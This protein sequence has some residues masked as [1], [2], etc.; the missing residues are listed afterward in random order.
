M[1]SKLI[2]SRV[3]YPMSDF[4]NLINNSNRNT[5]NLLILGIAWDKSSSYRSGSV[6]GPNYIR[7][8]TSS[9]VYNSFTETGTDL[10]HRWKVIDLGNV[11]TGG[12]DFDEIIEYISDQ[13]KQ[14]RKEE[15][16]LF[17]GG[18]H[19]VTYLCLHA[20]NPSNTGIIYFD[21]HPDLYNDYD[22]DTY[23]HACVLRRILDNTE[24]RPQNVI[25]IGIRASTKEQNDFSSENGVLVFSRKEVEQFGY[26][27]IGDRIKEKIGHLEQI[28]ISIDLDVLDPAYAPGVGNPEPA[29]LS[30]PTIV[31]L[32]HELSGLPIKFFDIVEINPPHD[33]SNITGFAAAKIIK[34]MF[35]IIP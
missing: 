6:Q 5:K 15:P 19:L 12:K 20:I 30:M 14:Y 4:F 23:S 31:D 2:Y 11:D 35:G 29:G 7:N 25:Q 34:E 3:G 21:A 17:L 32:I 18:D 22:G 26:E 28:Y 13:L 9:K 27:A 1:K 10:T 33:T 24:I 8:A 16:I